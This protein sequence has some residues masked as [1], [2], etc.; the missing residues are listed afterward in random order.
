M[1]C[2]LIITEVEILL[3]IPNNNMSNILEYDF[4]H[5]MNPA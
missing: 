1:L 4:S 3:K 2:N 5:E